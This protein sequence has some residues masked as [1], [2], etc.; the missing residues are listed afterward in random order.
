MGKAP[1]TESAYDLDE[2]TL[3]L[4]SWLV[5]LGV[6]VEVKSVGDMPEVGTATVIA[7]ARYRL[8]PIVLVLSRYA[9]LPMENRKS[10]GEVDPL[11]SLSSSS[12]F[13]LVG[14]RVRTAS[15][16]LPDRKEASLGDSLGAG[17]TPRSA[18]CWSNG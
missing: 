18:G 15:P 17:P 9:K 12:N 2:T 14:V 1:R 16:V 13:R 8:V 3:A 11:S 7:E 4:A 10:P 6:E 5:M